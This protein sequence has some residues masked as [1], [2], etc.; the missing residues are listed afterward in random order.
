MDF[1]LKTK[2]PPL[3]EINTGNQAAIIGGSNPLT[4]KELHINDIT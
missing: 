2:N 1:L 3:R 4:P